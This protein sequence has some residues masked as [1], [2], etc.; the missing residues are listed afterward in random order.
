MSNAIERYQTQAEFQPRRDDNFEVEDITD[1]E[2]NYHPVQWRDGQYT[3][4]RP[5]ST[6]PNYGTRF[7]PSSGESDAQ[8]RERRRDYGSV[9]TSSRSAE[10]NLPRYTSDQRQ[11]GRQP[12][13]LHIRQPGERPFSSAAYA[14]QRRYRTPSPSPPPPPPPRIRISRQSPPSSPPYS[15]FRSQSTFTPA[16]RF[17]TNPGLPSMHHRNDYTS[18]ARPDQYT[19][20][21]GAQI[22]RFRTAEGN[23]AYRRFLSS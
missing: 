22:P 11:Y 4:Q 2:D 13:S 10:R 12:N 8:F 16:T 3:S 9:P 17:Q 20:A 18:T 1:I 15:A 19:D 6:V 14:T 21:R 7:R 5:T 23:D